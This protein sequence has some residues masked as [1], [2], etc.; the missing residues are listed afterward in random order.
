L[1]ADHSLCAFAV[2]ITD[3]DSW[4]DLGSLACDDL[5]VTYLLKTAR[6]AMQDR[7][8]AWQ[9]IRSVRASREHA[10]QAFEELKAQLIDLEMINKKLNICLVEAKRKADTPSEKIT[11]IICF[12]NER[13][14]TFAPCQHFC[15]CATCAN[16]LGDEFPCPIC[17]TPVTSKRVT[18]FS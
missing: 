6:Q 10:Y 12:E 1:R 2:F 7:A 5:L 18:Y 14:I 9:E 16:H 4:L 17:Q 11:C 13:S 15:L 8:A 3:A